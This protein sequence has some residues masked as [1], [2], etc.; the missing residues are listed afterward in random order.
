MGISDYKHLHLHLRYIHLQY[1]AHVCMFKTSKS[2]RRVQTSL[3]EADH[4]PH[5]VPS[6]NQPGL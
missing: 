2:T 6:L 4:Y 1:Q 5:I 3:A